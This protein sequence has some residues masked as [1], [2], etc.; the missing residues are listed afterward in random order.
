[1]ANKSRHEHRAGSPIFQRLIGLETEYALHIPGRASQEPGSRYGLYLQLRD[2]F[3]RLIP[4][5][6]ARHLKE[7][8]FHAGGGAVWFETERPADGGGLI[9]GATAECRGLRQ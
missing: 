4:A 1:M 8:V 7:G 9:E 6:E 5:V 2:A 3:K